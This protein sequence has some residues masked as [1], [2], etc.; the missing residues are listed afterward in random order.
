MSDQV[1][2][3]AVEVTS[4]PYNSRRHVHQLL[5][6]R[7]KSVCGLQNFVAIASVKPAVARLGLRAISVPKAKKKQKKKR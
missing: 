3:K 7:R 2:I 4:C 1:E 5:I 6:R